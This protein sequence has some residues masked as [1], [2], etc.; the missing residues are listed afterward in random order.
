M[1]L[2]DQ[3]TITTAECNCRIKKTCLLKSECLTE[4]IV[5]LAKVSNSKSNEENSYIGLTE[6]S[7]K[8][9]LYKHR[10]LLRH[11]SKANATELSK[12]V[13]DLRD[14][15]IEEINVEWSILDKAPTNRKKLKNMHL[16]LRKNST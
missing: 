15:N 6:R 10:N 4:N 9:R 11:R 13:W 8:D 2:Q 12:Y 7:F 16:C 3:H 1:V 5:Y 14:E